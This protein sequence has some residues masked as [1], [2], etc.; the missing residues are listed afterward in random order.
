M[1]F[2]EEAVQFEKPVF[3]AG[4]TASDIQQILS[5]L[6]SPTTDSPSSSLEESNSISNSNRVVHCVDE[7]KRRRMVSNRES[8]RRSRWRKKRHL[9]DLTVRLNQLEFQNRDLK[10]QLGSVLE[11]CRVLWR[12]NDRLT[13]EYLSLQTRLS[14]LC[15]V[16]VTMQAMQRASLLSSSTSTLI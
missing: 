12:E 7:R 2:S 3:E 13:T 8:A 6:E 16:L 10:S 9:E 14:D 11:H 4:L 15:H 5:V 1:F